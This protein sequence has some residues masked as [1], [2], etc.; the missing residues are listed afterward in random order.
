MSKYQHSE[1]MHNLQS[2]QHI[3]PE[4]VRLLKPESV[5]D[6]GCGIGTFLHVFEKEGVPRILGVDGPWVNKELLQKYIKLDQF[7]EA[8]LEEALD[9]GDKFDLAISLEVAEHLS[10]ASAETM[11]KNLTSAAD[12]IVFSAA[13]PLQGG[14]NHINEQ[15]LSYWSKLF[16]KYNYESHDIL[17]PIFWENDSIFSWYKQNMVI[18]ASKSKQLK[19]NAKSFHGADIIHPELFTLKA[20]IAEKINKPK[21]WESVKLL[22][23]SIIR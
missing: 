2:P 18:F 1:L 17:R 9:L 15:W 14:Q 10:K 8:N 16:E 4:I 22:V 20:E 21:F 3:V 5:V 11:V 12:V 7:K 19:L 23:K 13:I 6:I